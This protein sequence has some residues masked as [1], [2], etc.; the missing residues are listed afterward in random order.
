MCKDNALWFG[1]ASLQMVQ[2]K[3]GILDSG[4]AK[5]G[6]GAAPKGPGKE[7]GP[8]PNGD[9]IGDGIGKLPLGKPLP[10]ERLPLAISADS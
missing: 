4:G 6:G 5:G 9:G 8:F 2:G 1:N 10:N 7:A 3:G